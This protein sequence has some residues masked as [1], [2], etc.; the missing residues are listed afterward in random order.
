LRITA[1]QSRAYYAGSWYRPGYQKSTP[2]EVGAVAVTGDHYKIELTEN[3][4]VL[5]ASGNGAFDYMPTRNHVPENMRYFALWSGRGFWA[6]DYEP[7]VY[8]TDVWNPL[9]GGHPECL[10]GD[11]LPAVD[12]PVTLLA[13]YG[14][15]LIIGTD[16][17]VYAVAGVISSYTNTAAARLEELPP[18]SAVITRTPGELGPVSKGTGS[19]VVADGILYFITRHGLARYEGP[20]VRPQ[21][22]GLAVQSLLPSSTTV[23]PLSNSMLAHD[24]VKHIIYMLVRELKAAAEADARYSGDTAGTTGQVESYIYAYSYRERDPRTGFGQWTLLGDIGVTANSGGNDRRYSAIGMRHPIG[25]APR[26]LVGVRCQ[27]AAP[28]DVNDAD[29]YSEDPD[30]SADNGCEAS[31]AASATVPWS[32]ESGNW[33]LG[34]PERKK[35]IHHLTAKIKDNSGSAATLNVAESL[36]G[37]TYQ[38]ASHKEDKTRVE[39]SIGGLAE[40]ISVKFSGDSI[41]DTEVFG[42]AIDA[43]EA[44]VY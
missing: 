12:S 11:F 18:H 19:Y 6:R 14:D 44:D 15:A 25:A 31:P 16:G 13:E 20:E 34:M 26:L 29:V 38:S 7:L 10:S 8:H 23:S 43:E 39:K 36:D 3:S 30:S 33:D 2:N 40:Q 4:H 5:Q 32:W 1:G 22:V 21:L 42:Y 37:A 17:G 27:Q 28:L 9:A 35:N 41:L 24:P